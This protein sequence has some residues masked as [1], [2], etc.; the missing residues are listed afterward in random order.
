MGF[1]LGVDGGNT[2]TVALV[3]KTS[4]RIV[5]YGRGGCADISAAPTE[6]PALA[7]ID[8]AV[9]A[10]LAMA[11]TRH[12]SITVGYFCLAGA[13]W[14]DDH[15]FLE[16]S[17]RRTYDHG[18]MFV[19]NDAFGALRAGSPDGTG[20]VVTCGTGVAVAARNQAGEFWHSGFWAEPLC[21][22]ELG[23]QTL[24]AV[25]RA[26]LGI[27]PPTALTA[28][29]LTR[30]GKPDEEQLLR[31]FEGRNVAPP[32][33]AQLAALAPLLLDVAEAGDETAGRILREHGT[34]VAGYA[35]AAAQRLGLDPATCTLVL[36]GGVF[37]H[38]STRLRSAILDGLGRRTGAAAA[39]DGGHEPA[40]GAL[41]LALE[42]HGVRVGEQ[43]MRE[44]EAS[45]P[46][47][48]LYAS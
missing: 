15:A 20:V 16:D 46:P 18:R 39:Q 45:L 35:R 42:A 30:F 33:T 37:R 43:V 36:N 21:G 25:Y 44:L 5:G 17:L 7:E 11:G 1:V 24:R 38:E 19:A 29:V 48:E 14:P 6:E 31:G 32:T 22:V 12:D 4:G 47:A 28:A 34:T 2:K 9:G 23:R 8:R 26:G 41:L 10:A 13:D 27:E 3:A 40:V